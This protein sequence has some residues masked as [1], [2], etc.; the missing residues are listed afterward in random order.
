LIEYSET[1]A[2]NLSKSLDGT[3]K[4]L[5][6]KAVSNHGDTSKVC[7]ESSQEK[8]RVQNFQKFIT[9]LTTTLMLII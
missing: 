9:F 7:Y 5:N 4:L 2:Q 3:L 8:E 6:F 1:V